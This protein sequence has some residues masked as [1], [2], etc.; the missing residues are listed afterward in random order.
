MK[1]NLLKEIQDILNEYK[2]GET[3]DFE[4]GQ[5]PDWW[6][7]QM[8]A[9][10]VIPG[11]DD[12]K[13]KI[14]DVDRDELKLGIKVEMEHTTDPKIAL[15]IALDHLAEDPKYY[16]MLSK[17]H[18]ESVNESLL[19]EGVNDPGI[20]K[21]VFLAGGPGSGKSYAVH[22]VFGVP[23]DITRGTTSL[24]LKVIN[25]DAAFEKNL[26]KAGVNPKDLSK[27]TNSIFKFYTSGNK[28]AREKAKKATKKLQTM[29]EQG[30]LGLI[31][32]GTGHDY[33]NIEKQQKRLSALGYDTYMIFVNTSLDI[34]KERNSK[35]ERVVPDKILVKSWEDVQ[36]NMGKFQSL[37]KN[38]FTIIDNS[39]IGNFSSMHKAK[40]S[41]T[42]KFVD[43]PIKNNIG[44]QWVATEKKL[45][46]I[47]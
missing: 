33:A 2:W 39:E 11:G 7:G 6:K 23:E 13:L 43:A 12:G 28:S 20:L 1:I 37:F 24:G 19:T 30:R 26:K 25:S 32:D 22:Q 17:I 38:N 31:I 42:K 36:N 35:R 8:A 16:T 47:K 21:A 3:E 15:E 34:A 29:F 18:K 9:E 4:Y 46:G 10:D 5:T 14:S 41:A 27:L 45:R 40:I 44:K